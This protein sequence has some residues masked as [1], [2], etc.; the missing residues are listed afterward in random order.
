VGTL[1]RRR[2]AYDFRRVPALIPTRIE[3]ELAR[4]ERGDWLLAAG[5]TVAIA[6]AIQTAFVIEAAFNLSSGLASADRIANAFSG[7]GTGPAFFVA[8]GTVLALLGLLDGVTR[9]GPLR[10]QAVITLTGL[11][12]TYAALLFFGIAAAAYL[13]VTDVEYTSEPSLPFDTRVVSAREFLLTLFTYGPFTALL[14]T[15]GVRIGALARRSEPTR[16][17][18]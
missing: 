7:F 11:A 3:E 6:A 8:L 13:V 5:S 12:V 15:V 10:R 17:K 16:R 2:L 4:W 1:R 18:I 9:L 14:A